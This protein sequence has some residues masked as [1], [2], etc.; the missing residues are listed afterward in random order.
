[1]V[2]AKRVNLILG[3]FIVFSIALSAEGESKKFYPKF[4]RNN[5]AT[6]KKVEQ[7]LIKKEGEYDLSKREKNVIYTSCVD[8]D[9]DGKNEIIVGDFN[10]WYGKNNCGITIYKNDKK[11]LKVILDFSALVG[12]EKGGKQTDFAILDE[13]KWKTILVNDY[14]Y[15]WKSKGYN[16]GNSLEK[17]EPYKITPEFTE[18]INKNFVLVYSG[19]EGEARKKSGEIEFIDYDYYVG[20][21]EFTQ[22]E[23]EAIVGKMDGDIKEYNRG[24][25][26]PM[27]GIADF[28]IKEFCNKLNKKY[29]L[30]K[31]YDRNGRLLDRNGNVTNDNSTVVGFR[32]LSQ[33][34][35]EFA[36]GG[37]IK[38][39]G[40]I[41]SGSNNI[42][43]V[44]WI[45]EKSGDKL[46][47][48]GLKKPNELGI[49]DMTGNV[50]E[51]TDDKDGY[52]PIIKGGGCAP[53]SDD[54]K[55][56][57]E[58]VKIKN[59]SRAFNS[60]IIGIR[61]GITKIEK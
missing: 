61:L 31:S 12:L 54:K 33:G 47:E 49:Y 55:D 59:S 34:E 41:Y 2:I 25:R 40:Y 60:N 7:Y 26:F 15:E 21:Y 46:H 57:E 11:G 9:R 16:E 22:E 36:A 56:W 45:N 48:V 32:L 23:Y 44:G 58:E 20:K 4:T 29:G 24:K 52:W 19:K 28:E 1:M 38:S 6:I 37:G 8:L 14:Y 3:L 18:Y 35:W 17:A 30:P 42:K 43:E 39:K 5:K 27:V 13:G 51:Y 53:M 10:N 50:W